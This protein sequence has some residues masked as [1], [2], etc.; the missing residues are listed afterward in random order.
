MLI[1]ALLT[2]TWLVLL[3]RYPSRAL[4]I[5]LAALVGLAL[6]ALAVLWQDSREQRR[7]EHLELSL[8]LDASCPA[9]LPLRA[10]LRNG[11][12]AV[13][14]ELRWQVGAYQPGDSINLAALHY[15]SPHYRVPQALLPGSGWQEC[16]PLPPLRPGYR[17]SSLEFRAEQLRGRFGE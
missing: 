2:F 6:L 9:D 15:D 5:S 3:V 10:R 8:A 13:L 17:A 14:H 12:D 1:G 16:L 4:A 11:S 7:L